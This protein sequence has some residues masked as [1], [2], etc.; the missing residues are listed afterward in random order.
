MRQRLAIRRRLLRR[1]YLY[2]AAVVLCLGVEL[3]LAP[4]STLLEPTGCPGDCVGWNDYR[5][6]E[7]YPPAHG[8]TR[9][10]SFQYTPRRGALLALRFAAQDD[11]FTMLRIG[12]E[13]D[14]PS[15]FFS[16]VDGEVTA[17]KE[18]ADLRPDPGGD[19]RDYRVS[20]ERG[21]VQASASGGG[22]ACVLETDEEPGPLYLYGSGRRPRIS[23]LTVRVEW[24]GAPARVLR[25]GWTPDELL[26][27]ARNSV[28]WILSLWAVVLAVGLLA[29]TNWAKE[30]RGRVVLLVATLVAAAA[31]IALGALLR[32]VENSLSTVQEDVWYRPFLSGEAIDGDLLKRTGGVNNGT[33][34]FHVARGPGARVV[35]LGGSSTYGEPYGPG[36]PRTYPAMLANRLAGDRC[37]GEDTVEMINLGTRGDQFRFRLMEEF[38]VALD[39]FQPDLI[40]VNNVFNNYIAD[41][42]VFR[43]LSAGASLLLHR[44]PSPDP[45][46][47]AFAARVQALARSAAARGVQVAF[48]EEPVN[49]DVFWGSNPIA[50]YQASLKEACRRAGVPVVEAQEAFDRR[51]GQ[52]LF[53]DYV[54]LTRWGNRL[55]AQ[56]ITDRLCPPAS[57]NAPPPDVR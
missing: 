36:D 24:E 4:R 47:E 9:T 32:F 35:A 25:N 53:Y 33:A 43:L 8:V 7:A 14:A 10:V 44:K 6:A 48:V 28:K 34:R 42:T 29:E 5:I 19:A 50:G 15:G 38:E 31:V 22:E 26:A 11:R 16:F 30:H 1:W 52:F 17:L 20:F 12:R 41:R 54:H 27:A 51:R 46:A 21:R 13:V 49:R 3:A 55:L 18:C 2:L 57:G 56:R 37:L 39:A 45:L 40:L 23:D